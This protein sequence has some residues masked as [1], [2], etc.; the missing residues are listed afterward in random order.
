MNSYETQLRTLEE[1][2][3]RFRREL[4]KYKRSAKEKVNL[5]KR[6]EYSILRNLFRMSKKI[7]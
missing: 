2:R 1:E 4:H 3:D 5:L 6:N 7:N